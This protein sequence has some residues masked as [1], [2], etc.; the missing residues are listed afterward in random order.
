L[1]TLP[2]IAILIGGVVY[3]YVY[4]NVRAELSEM[5]EAQDQ[6]MKILR[7]QLTLISRKS[8]MESE[9][10]A[11]GEERKAEGTG[12]IGG[13][14]AALAAANMQQL[15][16]G[17]IVGKGGAVLA[18]TLEKPEDEQGFTVVSET[19][20]ITFADIRAFVDAVC[21]LEAETTYIGLKELDVRVKNSV[22][23]RELAVR[24]KV[25]ALTD[26]K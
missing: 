19:L 1:L 4:L 2:F 12:F 14:T 13:A 8:Q 21:A 10:Q 15:V 25:S 20:D 11:L 17:I 6:K 22:D 24:L 3:R 26:G 16:K 5:R 9:R 18:E 7:K 23:P